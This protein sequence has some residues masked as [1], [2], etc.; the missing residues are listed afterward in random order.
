MV[1]LHL[2][3]SAIRESTKQTNQRMARQMEAAH[4]ASLA[5][6]EFGFRDRL[7]VLT[8]KDFAQRDFLPFVE[9]RFVDKPNT[10]DY[11]RNGV[12]N[13]V[14]FPPLAGCTLD[15]ITAEKRSPGL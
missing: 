3:R 5:K 8:L 1:S 14:G 13:L 11:Y 4:R 6:G 15:T 2:E 7:P 9:S 12:K 10:L